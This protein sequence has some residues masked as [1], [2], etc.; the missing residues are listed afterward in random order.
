MHVH[1]VVLKLLQDAMKTYAEERKKGLTV[2]FDSQTEDVDSST[3]YACHKV[4]KY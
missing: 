4:R 1:F 2:Q 3:S